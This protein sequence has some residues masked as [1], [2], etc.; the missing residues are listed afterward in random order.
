M[1]YIKRTNHY[2]GQPDKPFV[3][4]IPYP[5]REDAQAEI[6]TLNA[7]VYWLDNGECSRPDFEIVEIAND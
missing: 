3:V 4:E 5:T 7:R 1:Y 6:D 2:Y